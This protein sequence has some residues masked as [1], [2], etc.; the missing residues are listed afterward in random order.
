M[1]EQQR[2]DLAMIRTK[3]AN[4][5]R[6]AEAAHRAARNAEIGVSDCEELLQRIVDLEPPRQARTGFIWARQPTTGKW[7]EIPVAP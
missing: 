7:D 4:A 1:N 3:L 6:Y 5:K 2:T